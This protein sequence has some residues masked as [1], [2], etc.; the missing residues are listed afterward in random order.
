VAGNSERAGERN[1]P[2]AGA[3]TATAER[4]ALA[5]WIA[6]VAILVARAAS[7]FLP[8]THLW[9]L[10]LGRFLAPAWGWLPWALAAAALAPPL[11]RAAAPALARLGNALARARVAG[12]LACMALAFLLVW[13]LPDRVRFVGDF[14]LRQGTVEEAER[15]GVIFPQA[16]PLDV[17]IHYRLPLALA[18]AGLAD[19]NR[20]GRLLGAL[21]AAL[22]AALAL[23]FARVLGRRG[24]SA[25]A[26]AALVFFGGY[27]G[28]FTG[29]SKAFGELVLVTVAVGVAGIAVLRSDPDRVPG[30]A[31]L[32]LGIAVAVGV[33]LHRSA[34]AL[35]PALALVWAWWLPRAGARWRSPVAIAAIAIPVATVAFLLPRIVADVR[36]W[37]VVHFAPA[38]VRARGGPFNAALA[39][40]R[41]LDLLNLVLLF[42]PL[43]LAAPFAV[44]WLRPAGGRRAELLF[45]ALL[46]AP[47]MLA[48]PFIHPAQGLFRD[49]DD[50]AATGAALALV[51]AWIAGAALEAAPA[52]A[53]VGVGLAVLAAASSVQ[54]LAAQSDFARGLERVR[55]FVA[56]PPLRTPAERAKTWDYLGIVAYRA[57]RWGDAAAAFGRSAETGPSERVMLEWGMSVTNTGDL[58]GAADIYR[59][60]L[61][62]FP[63]AALGWLGLAAVSSRLADAAPPGP[64]QSQWVAESR[65]A[66]H[67]LLVLQPQN[68]DAVRLLEYLWSRY[69]P[70][71]DGSRR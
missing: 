36:R 32:A 17:L 68:P 9:S 42:S 60:M 53:W 41:P 11:A 66:A 1:A 52:R 65:R 6:A 14:L 40:G 26:T 39:D 71:S 35:T 48:A 70:E 34:L 19:A 18:Q 46:A 10:G 50:F 63:D 57:E 16:L 12:T 27:L 51:V 24:V 37:D 55:G 49:W 20:A 7:A 29:Y 4:A 33:A 25:A 15:P 67:R 47:L 38:E 64:A 31:L 43:A 21:E 58:A 59:R 5:F 28:M 44:A 54:W 23:A 61:E 2:G 13:L 69:G 45:L 30:R 62:R 8:T 3:A 22:L 56:E